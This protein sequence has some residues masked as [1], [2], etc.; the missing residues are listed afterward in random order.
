MEEVLR[1]QKL[2]FGPNDS[3]GESIKLYWLISAAATCEMDL[4]AMANK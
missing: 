1:M 4:A 3:A 2:L